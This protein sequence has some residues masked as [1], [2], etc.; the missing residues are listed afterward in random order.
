MFLGSQQK[1]CY[2][3]AEK[4]CLEPGDWHEESLDSFQVS[5]I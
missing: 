5:Y 2:E 3:I 4:P 1:K